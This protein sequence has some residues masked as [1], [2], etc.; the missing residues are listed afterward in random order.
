MIEKLK[1][2]QNTLKNINFE[3][4]QN[5]VGFFSL[6]LKIDMRNHPENYKKP[7]KDDR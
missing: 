3:T 7:K 1:K 2:K 5:A 4:K 6:L